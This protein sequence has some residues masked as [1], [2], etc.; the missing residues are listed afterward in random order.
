MAETKVYCGYIDTT[1][2]GGAFILKGFRVI[3]P[4]RKLKLKSILIDWQ[5][6]DTTTG[7]IVP[8]E[9]N[10]GQKMQLSIGGGGL[11][12]QKIGSDLN[13]TSGPAFTST[14][15]SFYIS[16]PGQTIFNSFFAANEINFLLLIQNLILAANPH[17]H[18]WSII[19]EIEE[20]NIYQS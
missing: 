17:K 14:G 19:V 2:N 7:L 16:K 6:L 13:N 18:T 4:N 9:A 11:P 15:Y 5:I 8:I 10:T 12:V 20:R 1:I 3:S